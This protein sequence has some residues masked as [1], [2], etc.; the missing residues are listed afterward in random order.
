MLMPLTGVPAGFWEL[1]WEF[2]NI[3]GIFKE[4]AING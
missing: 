3:L 2:A 4:K 1:F